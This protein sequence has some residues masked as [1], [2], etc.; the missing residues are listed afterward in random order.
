[1]CKQTIDRN[2]EKVTVMLPVVKCPVQSRPEV[3][4]N[5][6]VR[7][8]PQVAKP[9]WSVEDWGEVGNYDIIPHHTVRHTIPYHTTPH[10]T[11]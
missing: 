4:R 2:G 5:C 1:M 7:E 9:K 3:I 8:C 11:P 6:F 10:S